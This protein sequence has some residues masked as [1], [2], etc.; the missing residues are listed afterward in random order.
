MY[1]FTYIYMYVYISVYMYPT[2]ACECVHY[3]CV[4]VC[5]IRTTPPY[6]VRV[7]TYNCTLEARETRQAA[8]ND[9]GACGLDCGNSR[10]ES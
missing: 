1:T 8:R 2:C 4:C 6:S 7:D 5:H 9:T 10:F 3:I